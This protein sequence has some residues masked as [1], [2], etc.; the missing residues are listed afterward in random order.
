MEMI[1]S[2]QFMQILINEIFRKFVFNKDTKILINVK[3]NLH[4]QILTYAKLTN[5]LIKDPQ[6]KCPRVIFLPG[7]ITLEYFFLPKN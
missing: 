1:V 7:K 5:I 3:I 4:M 6:K 2:E